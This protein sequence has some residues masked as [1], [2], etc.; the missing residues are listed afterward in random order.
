[1]SLSKRDPFLIPAFSLRNKLLRAIWGI[2]YT[3][4][5]R[6]SPRPFHR[7][8][9]FLLRCFGADIGKNCHIYSKARVWAPWNLVCA[10]TVAI[11]NEA[12]IYNPCLVTLGS[13]STISQQAYLCGATHLYDDPHFPLVAFPITIGAKAWI[14]AR[15]AVQPGVQVG[16]GAVLG[17]GAIAT[18]DLEPWTVYAGVPARRIKIRTKTTQTKDKEIAVEHIY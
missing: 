5:F 9:A 1:M 4:F 11:A 15:S 13:H 16:E 18:K 7:W 2:V 10:D 12:E 17:L 6:T 3:I 14:C 8:R